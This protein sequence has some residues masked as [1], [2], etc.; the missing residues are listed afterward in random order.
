MLVVGSTALLLS[1]I[2]WLAIDPVI[3]AIYFERAPRW[4]NELI[5]NRDRHDLDRYRSDARALVGPLLTDAAILGALLV[6]GSLIRL[7]VRRILVSADIPA[8]WLKVQAWVSMAIRHPI[9]AMSATAAVAVITLARPG[10]AVMLL[11]GV[12]VGL[13]VAPKVS[14]GSGGALDSTRSSGPNVL[15]RGRWPLALGAVTAAVLLTGLGGFDF[16]EDEFLVMNAAY[17]HAMV[18]DYGGWDWIADAPA[19]GRPYTR[20]FP[21]TWII[22]RFIEAFGMSEGLTRLPGVIAGTLLVVTMFVVLR[23]MLG[24]GFAATVGALFVLTAYASIFRY[25]RMYALV[26]PLAFVWTVVHARALV[27]LPRRP[28]R[29]AMWGAASAA[30]GLLALLLHVNTLSLAVAFAIPTMVAVHRYARERLSARAVMSIWVGAAA[31]VL[32][33]ASLVLGEVDHFLSFFGRRNFAYVTMLLDLPVPTRLSATLGSVLI[34]VAVGV[35]VR[36]PSRGTGRQF[37]LLATGSAAFALPFFVLVADRYV[38]S[39]YVSHVRVLTLALAAAGLAALVE[40]AS[41]RVVKGGLTIGIVVLLAI[42]WHGMVGSLYGDDDSYGRYTQAY[43]L[44]AEELDPPRDVVLGQFFRTYYA[45]DPR[46]VDVPILSLGMNG[47]VGIT[48]F[49]A[50]VVSAPRAWVTWE[51]RKSYHLR[52]EVRLFVMTNGRQLSG[53]GVDASNVYL[54]LIDTSIE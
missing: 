3:T 45:Q 18:G 7:D 1:S 24:S 15:R 37:L 50:M 26:I 13:A 14:W 19:D 30:C 48:D 33:G 40:A 54:F 39:L 8:R 51:Q 25:A 11:L 47:S 31:L 4:A 16:R 36:S 20:A 17:S 10:L 34:G 23:R 52:P 29:A 35:A 49:E 43:A 12:L 21:H 41:R 28:G 42:Q 22:A 53:P 9:R 44:L 6:L 32:A 27:L 38:A 2:A 5:A 46:F